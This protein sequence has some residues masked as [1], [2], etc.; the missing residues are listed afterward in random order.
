MTAMTMQT[1]YVSCADTAKLIRKTLAETFPGVKFS[2]RSKT[3]SGG[4]SVTIYYTDGPPER[5]VERAVSHYRG[6]DFDGMIDLATAIYHEV[7][8]QRI[9]YG[10]DYIHAVRR[11][12]P[13]FL[14]WCSVTVAEKYD[15]EPLEVLQDGE[16]VYLDTRDGDP[17]ITNAPGPQHGSY[18]SDLIYQFANLTD[19]RTFETI[20]R[21][22]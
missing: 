19:A 12:T 11:F 10:S 16:Y 1:V 17:L 13:S 2:V 20:D 6:E 7:D 14:A 9:N 15:R 18:L 3:Y 21:Y 8:G 4:A 5:L 22:V